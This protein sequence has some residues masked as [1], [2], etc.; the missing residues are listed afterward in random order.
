MRKFVVLAISVVMVISMTALLAGCGDKDKGKDSGDKKDGKPVVAVVVAD[1]FGDRSFYDSSK[2]GLDM[3]TDEGLV[4]PMTIECRGE[5]FE[6]QMR[7]AADKADIII[8]VGWEFG[9]IEKVADDYPDKKFIWVDN[10]GEKNHENIL[11]INYAQNE[12]SYLVGYIAAKMSKTG[13]I[14]AVGGLDQDTINDFIVGYEQGAKKANPDIK[15]V[16]NY[17]GD[18]EDPAQGKECAQA[19]H[20]KG[21]DIIFAVAG[22]SGSGVIESGKEDG[23]YVI[24]VDS[25]QKYIAPDT[26]ICSMV[27]NVDESI[28][29]VV[30]DF[31]KDGKFEGNRTWIADMA[32][33]FIS[34]G[35]GEKDAAQQVSDELK[36]EVENIQKDI[37]D[38]K[39]KVDTARQ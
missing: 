7:N 37:V 30:K 13:T 4:R 17:V 22:N 32:T 38:G 10:A 34:V 26:I 25:D 35:Y 1:G 20:S 5:N 28:Y 23:Y 14:G 39:I 3:L 12:G 29:K 6:Q 15:I 18:F 11:Y 2:K 21:A 16:K 31:V 27:K 19:L 36:K 24:G 33:G 9:D 8:P